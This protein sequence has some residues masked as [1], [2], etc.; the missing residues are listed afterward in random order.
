MRY[1]RYWIFRQTHWSRSRRNSRGSMSPPCSAGTSVRAAPPPRPRL[2]SYRADGPRRG[3]PADRIG[4]HGHRGPD[5]TTRQPHV[6]PRVRIG[7]TGRRPRLQLVQRRYHRDPVR[8]TPDYALNLPH[9]S[10]SLTRSSFTLGL[11]GVTILEGRVGQTA[12]D[13]GGLYRV[14]VQSKSVPRPV[15]SRSLGWTGCR[16]LRS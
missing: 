3:R 16:L 15:H 1:R 9:L 10:S 5:A 2:R 4:Y 12:T 13:A 7:T 8:R 14:F 6:K 11:D